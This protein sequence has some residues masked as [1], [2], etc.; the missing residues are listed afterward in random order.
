MNTKK[1]TDE[2]EIMDNFAMK[3]E[4]LREALDKIAKINQFLGGNKLTLRGVQKLLKNIP[5]NQEVTIADIGCGN[6]DMI[7]KL[8]DFGAVNDLNL[9]LI[10]IDANDF[11]VNY[12]QKLSILYPNIRY[13]KLDIFDPKF[14]DL[15]YDVALCTLTL[16]HFKDIEIEKLLHVFYNNSKIGIVVNDLHRSMVSYRLFQ[17][18]CLLFKLNNMSKQDGLVSILR[19]FKKQELVNFSEKLQLKKYS[20]QWKWAFRYQ[21]IIRKV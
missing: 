2:V 7:R 12:A 17:A 11:T 21:W 18:V 10:G 1:R 14:E 6:G 5:K 15:K 3:G 8:A 20:I 19:G 13:V 9:K 4:I 16:H